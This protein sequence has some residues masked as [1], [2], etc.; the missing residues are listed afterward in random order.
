MNTSFNWIKTLVPG[1]AVTPGEYMDAMTLSG[2]KVEG[3]SRMDADLEKIVIGQITSIT[4]HPDADKLVICQTDIGTETIQIV[5]GA[6]N[7]TEGCKVPVVLDGGKS[8]RQPHGRRY[9]NQKRTAARSGI[10]RYAL[11]DRGARF[12]PRYVPAG[13]GRGHLSFAG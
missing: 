7:V 9:Q 4:P 11:F 8:R 5:T 3:Y 6:K 1:L 13:A 2:S 10:Q 12:Q